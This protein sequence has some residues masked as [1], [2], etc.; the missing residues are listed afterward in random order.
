MDT[1]PSTSPPTGLA[2][3]P[4]AQ[5]FLEPPGFRWGKLTSRH[6]HA[7][8][9]GHLPASGVPAA[10]PAKSCVL[11]GGLA[12]FVEKFF[13]TAQDFSNRGFDVWCS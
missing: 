11:V 13:E 3:P 2:P 6:G 9:W 7:L 12:E 4:V 10:V 8:R 5:R 1:S